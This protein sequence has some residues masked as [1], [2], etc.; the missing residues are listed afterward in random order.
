MYTRTQINLDTNTKVLRFVENM[1]SDGTADKYVLEDFSG[2][3]RVSARSYLG[4]LYASSEFGDHI[5]LV[6]LTED[7]VFPNFVKEFQV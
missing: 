3:N 4:A 7:N 6:N 1:N 5:F 2:E